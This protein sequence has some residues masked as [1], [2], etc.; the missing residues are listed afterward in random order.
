MPGR[1]RLH[2]H[3]LTPFA[4][5]SGGRGSSAPTLLDAYL[6]SGTIDATDATA[7]RRRE[8]AAQ[9]Q[10]PK[11]VLFGHGV[12]TA[13]DDPAGPKHISRPDPLHT[14]WK[15]VRVQRL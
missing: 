13:D 4:L 6:H 11:A 12:R 1:E 7:A 15:V 5:V 14:K 10:P 2:T 3:P 9:R 8:D